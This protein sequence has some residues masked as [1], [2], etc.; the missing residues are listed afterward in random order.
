M[1]TPSL[2]TKRFK[3]TKKT[4][5]EVQFLGEKIEI[6]KLS[7]TDVLSIQALTKELAGDPDNNVPAD[8]EASLKGLINTIQLGA[9]ELAGYEK[10][11][12]YDIGIDD[13][14][15]LADEILKFSGMGSNTK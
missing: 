10:E 2:A 4:A 3:N 1:T 9:P 11:E 13:L 14:N 7:V 6:F 8:P 15:K 5:K 12:L